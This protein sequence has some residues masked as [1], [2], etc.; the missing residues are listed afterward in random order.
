[1]IDLIV[2][3]RR[4]RAEIF[5]NAAALKDLAERD[6]IDQGDAS[7]FLPLAFLAP[8]L[9]LA[10]LEGRQPVSLTAEG[11]KRLGALPLDWASQRT[12]L[13]A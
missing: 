11:L 9:T 7:R 1:M 8:D 6:G 12:L 3:A 5:A 2:V 13:G 10:I 4:W